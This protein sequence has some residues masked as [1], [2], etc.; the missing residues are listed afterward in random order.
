M[1][2][3]IS[4]PFPLSHSFVRDVT[5]SPRTDPDLRASTVGHEHPASNQ[6]AETSLTLAQ[7]SRRTTS[8]PRILDYVAETR[9]RSPAGTSTAN[10][11]GRQDR[12]LP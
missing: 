6:F 12:D 9:E 10:R 8:R 5:P 4:H 3:S 7:A 2:D 1:G 11:S